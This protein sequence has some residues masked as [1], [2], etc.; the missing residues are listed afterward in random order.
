[1][2]AGRRTIVG[3]NDY[4]IDEPIQIPILRMDPEGERRQVARLQSIRRER[5]NREATRCIGELERACRSGGNV[6]PSLLEAVRAMCTLQEMCDV[7]REVFGAYQE[8]AVV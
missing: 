8:V 5:D 7:M 2:D 4:T 1:M 3:V 6:M